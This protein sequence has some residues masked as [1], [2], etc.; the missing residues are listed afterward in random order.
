MRRLACIVS[1]R[2]TRRKFDNAQFSDCGS[3]L[4]VSNGNLTFTTT[5]YGS[6][7][8]LECYA[9]YDANQTTISCL[10]TGSWETPTCTIKDCGSS[11]TVDNGKLT[12][13]N[14]TYGSTASLVCNAGYDANANNVTCLVTGTWYPP[15]CTI[16]DCGSSLTVSN[17]VLTFTN[18][19]YGS[20]ASL[21][22]DTGYDANTASIGCLDTG[23]WETPTCTIKDCGSSL[24]VSN[25]A[26]TFTTTT[27][28]SNAS[29]VCDTGYDA[30]T[31]T[32]GCLDTGSWETPTC[33]I[34]D[35]G[36]SL[37][38]SN[39]ALTF[40]TTTYGSNASLVCDTGYDANSATIGCLDTGSWETPT[41]TIKDCGSSLTVSDGT[42]TFTTTTYGS[43]ATL[44]CDKGYDANAA[45]IGCLDTGSWDTATCTI[46]DCGTPSLTNGAL[47]YTTTTYLSDANVTCDKGYTASDDTTKCKANGSWKTVSCDPVDCGS[48]LPT[49]TNGA[50]T[51]DDS[52]QTTYLSTA[53]VTC[54]SGFTP[55]KSSLNCK[56]NGAW[57]KAI[58]S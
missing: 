25:G 3:S 50:A 55:D 52:A 44:V 9:G 4:A 47:A 29:L 30:N 19:T 13:T 42:L 38:V 36:S 11:L 7:A 58:C 41:C 40:T 43:N 8:S 32:I 18:T 54:E 28:G 1:D 46:T 37:T 31:A 51:L 45:T 56:A 39:G 49:I 2:T 10:D 53:S 48:T 26:L 5:T 27:Y 17:G 20:N 34:K 57:S 12:F 15:L 16:K 33:T 14:T 22:C 6:N 23:S 24:T 35:C 21:A